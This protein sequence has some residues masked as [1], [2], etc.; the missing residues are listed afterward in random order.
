M[1]TLHETVRDYLR[2]KHRLVQTRIDNQVRRWA[3]HRLWTAQ[4]QQMFSTK[5]KIIR[6]TNHVRYLRLALMRRNDH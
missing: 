1:I 2:T 6:N 5:K 4:G 3:A